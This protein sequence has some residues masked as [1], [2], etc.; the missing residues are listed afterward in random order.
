MTSIATG[1]VSGTSVVLSSISQSYRH[2]YLVLTSAQLSSSN[3]LTLRLN[4]DT[5][6]NYSISGVQMN[7]TAV[8]VRNADTFFYVN[9]GG[10]PAIPTTANNDTHTIFIENYALAKAKQIKTS[11]NSATAKGNAV[12]G[13]GSYQSNTAITSLTLGTSGGT[14][15]FSVGT[16]TLYG[17]N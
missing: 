17:V 14:A 4:A 12:Y 9:A 1:T 2:L 3:D 6:A 8:I 11:A 10:N 7:N 5:G 13:F 16:Y 15:T